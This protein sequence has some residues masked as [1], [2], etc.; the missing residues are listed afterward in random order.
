[1]W[2]HVRTTRREAMQIGSIGLLGL[3]T[4]HLAGMREAMA[5]DRNASFGKAKSCIFIF[6]SGGLAQHE[7]FDMKPDA[8]E[9]IRGEF[10]P[11]ATRTPGLQ[12]CEHLPMLAERS[13]HWALCRSLTHPS[14]DHS[15]GHHIMLT[16]RSTLPAGFNPNTASRTDYPSIAAIAGVATQARNNLPTAAII[17]ERLVHNTG[18]VLPG[19]HAGEMGVARDPWFVEASPFHTTSYG[20]FPQYHFDHQQRGLADDRIY[21]APQLTLPEGLGLTQLSGRLQLLDL[22]KRQSV[23]LE[24]CAEME[25]FDRYRQSAVSLMTD[26][27]IQKALD[28]TRADDHTQERYGKNSFGWSLL[29]ARRLV[30]V[31]VNLVQVNL[32]N[33]ESWDTHGNAFPHLKD[34]LLPP[35]DR[36]LSAL[37][38]DLVTSGQL[39]ETLI[40][41]AGEFGRTPQVTLLPQHYKL[42]GR[43]HW[44][45]VQSV[46]F[47]GGGIPGGTVVGR[48]D[49]HGAYPVDNPVKPENFA[50]TIY[51]LLG[52]PASA[53]WHDSTNRPHT[54]YYGEP[55][56]GFV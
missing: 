35:T 46:W 54:I 50:A 51:D 31:G 26:P 52:I 42:P 18:R 33:N 48:S 4:N 38:D 40:V 39:D 9:N 30:E 29:M 45:A 6:L 17:P 1:M 16:G 49:A 43:D 11:I 27:K 2:K 53:T 23:A 10:R 24:R 47:A 19:Q 28:V 44:G 34:R 5:A 7:S 36:A 8:P 21:Q 32:G 22:L 3:G 25:S 12:I 55:I 20:A 13:Q 56:A 41:M 14:N 15:A 37:L